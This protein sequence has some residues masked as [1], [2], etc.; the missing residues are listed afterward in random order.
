MM[1]RRIDSGACSGGTLGTSHGGGAC[2]KPYVVQKLVT[3]LNVEMEAE[4]RRW[5]SKKRRRRRVRVSTGARRGET[6]IVV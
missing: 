1:A 4:D 6:A 2:P 5:S 3:A